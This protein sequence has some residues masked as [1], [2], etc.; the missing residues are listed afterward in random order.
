MQGVTP[1][2]WFDDQAE[3]AANHYI[4]IFKETGR[5]DS[6]VTHVSRYSESSANAAGRPPGSVMTVGFRLDGQDF[7]GLNGG[8]AFHFTE[9]ISFAV[10]CE[11][12]DEIDHFWSRLSDGGEEGVCGWL[13][14]RYGL[15]WQIVAADMERM[16][17][18]GTPEQ[19][20]RVMAEILEMKKIDIATLQRA[21]KGG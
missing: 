20:E 15:S 17:R 14:D 10:N 7:V 6:E 19:G 12:Q 3:E 16:M 9:A 18:E 21:F 11:T 13:K 4:S 2:L 8:P 5:T 1:F